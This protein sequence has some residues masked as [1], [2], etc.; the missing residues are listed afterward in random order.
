MADAPMWF[1]NYNKA[2]LAYQP[3]VHGM[4]SNPVEAMFQDMDKIWVE[5]SSPRAKLK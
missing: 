3:W 1:F 4:Q 5:E 2:V